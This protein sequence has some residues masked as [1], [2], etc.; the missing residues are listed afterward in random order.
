MNLGPCSRKQRIINRAKKKILFVSGNGVKI[1][2]VGRLVKKFFLHNFFGQK[3]V[4]YAC[5]TLI[6]SWEG[7]KNFRVEIF[8]NENL[9]G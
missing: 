8:L 1:N 5:F 6:R 4:F 2:R 3:C 7:E 9:L